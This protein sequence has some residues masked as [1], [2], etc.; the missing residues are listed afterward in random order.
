MTKR[1]LISPMYIRYCTT[2]CSL[3]L[4]LSLFLLHPL[5][6]YARCNTYFISS[7]LSILCLCV[8]QLVDL[9]SSVDLFIKLVLCFRLTEVDHRH[10]LIHSLRLT[11]TPSVIS[12]SLFR[13]ISVIMCLCLCHCFC[14]C[15]SVSVFFLLCFCVS[16]PVLSFVSILFIS[17]CV[18]TFVS[19]CLTGFENQRRDP[20][21]RSCGYCAMLQRN[22]FSLLCQRRLCKGRRPDR[23]QR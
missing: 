6:S 4:L 3:F 14:F 15:F 2:M 12:L 22:W 13:L 5:C 7:W 11:H 9:P 8:C 10:S 23:A 16:M 19:L 1:W 21:S 20:R 17:I 18:S